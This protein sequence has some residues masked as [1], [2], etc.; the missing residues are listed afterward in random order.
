MRPP[1]RL[2]KTVLACICGA[3][4]STAVQ[5]S[6]VELEDSELSDITGQAFINLTTDSANGLN[7]TRINFGM[8]MAA[9][10]NIKKLQLGLY[11]RAG[12]AA[13][14]ADIDINNFALG[15][16]NDATG[17][18]TPWADIVG[19]NFHNKCIVFRH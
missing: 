4:V 7:F 19:K 14:T 17:Q 1:F 6:M 9:Q 11:S 2:A 3:L 12:E 8:D 15:T 13:N 18:V 5:A 16:V 10:L